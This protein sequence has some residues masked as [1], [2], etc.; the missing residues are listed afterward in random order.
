MSVS[1]GRSPYLS[2]AQRRGGL[3]QQKNAVLPPLHC[4]KIPVFDN[5]Q[6]MDTGVLM[7]H[8]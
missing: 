4:Q 6:V 1:P 8:R 3:K 7:H 2:G 5:Y